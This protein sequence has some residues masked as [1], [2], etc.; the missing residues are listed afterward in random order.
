M[1]DINKLLKQLGGYV[2]P[3]TPQEYATED[4]S[5]RNYLANKINPALDASVNKI[6]PEDMG[7]VNIPV[8]SQGEQKDQDRE[9][10]K[11]ENMAMALMP[12]TIGKAPS[13]P[14]GNVV[15]SIKGKSKEAAANAVEEL[16]GAGKFDDLEFDK[17]TNLR[18]YLRG[19]A[20]AEKA[21]EPRR[22]NTDK[23]LENLITEKKYLAKK[24]QSDKATEK[25]LKK[26]AEEIEY[27]K[28]SNPDDATKAS[29]E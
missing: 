19:Q 14:F 11:P 27:K 22:H 15:D 18:R 10:L 3:T 12:G 9:T 13:M 2:E 1:A 26:L 24:I 23:N 25:K 4:S 20:N 28:Q 17:L 6:L 7:R 16:Q 5:I 8:L 21:L 29:G